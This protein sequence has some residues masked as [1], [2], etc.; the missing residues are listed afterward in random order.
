MM[1]IGKT[2]ALQ[3]DLAAAIDATLSLLQSF[4]SSGSLFF[5]LSLS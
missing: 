2:P 3:V 5:S 1:R 4:E